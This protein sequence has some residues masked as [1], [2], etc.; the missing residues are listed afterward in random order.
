MPGVLVIE[1]RGKTI[2]QPIEIPLGDAKR[3]VPP[4]QVVEKYV[5]N[6]VEVIGPGFARE[7]AQM[8]LAIETLPSIRPV[9][10]RLAKRV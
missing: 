1:A 3:P 6:A 4:A 7:T 9:L 8:L 5:R 2:M 10:D